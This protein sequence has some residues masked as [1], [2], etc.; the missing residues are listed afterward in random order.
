MRDKTEERR[1]SGLK[2]K[3]IE[4]VLATA[5]LYERQHGLD[6]TDV[7]LSMHS[8]LVRY[9]G[10]CCPSQKIEALELIGQAHQGIINGC[11]AA[12][13]DEEELFSRLMFREIDKS[14]GGYGSA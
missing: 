9:V 4:R 1:I 3:L 11:R 5:R 8:A 6:G 12:R 7:M 13:A 14:G 2:S 10:E